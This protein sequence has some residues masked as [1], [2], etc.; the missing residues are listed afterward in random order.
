MR[1]RIRPYLLYFWVTLM[2]F[3]LII[4]FFAPNIFITIYPG[5]AGVLFKR[6]GDGTV[7]DKYYTEGLNIIFPWDKM[8]IY[9][10]RLQEQSRTLNVLTK[11]GL[12]VETEVSVRFSPLI[13]TL[14]V[15]HKHIGPDYADK[16][17]FPEVEARTRDVISS[18]D[19]EELYMTDR[20]LIQQ[21]LSDS[22]LKDINDQVIIDTLL[23][24][25]GKARNYIIFEDLFLKSI[26]LPEQVG[27]TIE[28]K[29]VAEQEFLT[30]QYILQAEQQE[31]IRKRIEAQ[32]ID[33][34]QT[35]SNIPILKWKGLEVTEQL[36]R[37]PNAKLVIMGTDQNLPILLNGEVPDSIP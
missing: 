25:E 15:L 9:D 12:M 24:E 30:Y 28:K 29:V 3:I 6:L 1:K 31:V 23:T 19:V 32:G 26:V 8:Y 36:A 7:T 13:E 4:L 5:H 22:I 35:I 16:V 17:V 27:S 33:T 18:Y 14:G 37:S 20:K 34:F 2:V 21:I 10:I 11:D